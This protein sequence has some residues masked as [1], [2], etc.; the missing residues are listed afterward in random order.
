MT[1]KQRA[2]KQL[3]SLEKMYLL[4]ENAFNKWKEEND[5][6]K[7]LS[8]L[9]RNMKIIMNRK[10]LPVARKWILYQNFLA[11][12]ANFKR[13]IREQKKNE[14]N[15]IPSDTKTSIEKKITL[16]RNRANQTEEVAKVNVKTN[17]DGNIVGND[18]VF[19]LNESD[20]LDDD[21]HMKTAEDLMNTIKNNPSMLQ[22]VDLTELYDEENSDDK[23][24]ETSNVQV[25][26]LPQL[27]AKE[28]TEL[29][30][31]HRKYDNFLISE[32][33]IIAHL[34]KASKTVQD[35]YRNLNPIA[36]T[37]KIQVDGEEHEIDL[38]KTKIDEDDILIA[39]DTSG[40]QI[41]IKASDLSNDDL[42]SI[43]SYLTEKHNQIESYIDEEMRESNKTPY[44]T[45]VLKDG[46][47]IVKF[48]NDIV[49][50]DGEV[51]NY[52]ED[53][54]NSGY[55]ASNVTLRQIL[56]WGKQHV[57]G[58]KYLSKLPRSKNRKTPTS[59]IAS[60]GPSSSSTPIIHKEKKT[61]SS[62]L[63]KRSQECNKY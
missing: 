45:V 59:A 3:T 28:Q 11:R 37:K 47:T 21:I 51:L 63:N 19:V 40:G 12:Y 42:Y 39:E 32:N 22:N 44:E 25:E 55:E 48:K 13:F 61:I 53:Y 34:N 26:R 15:N 50:A 58:E 62:K 36:R 46:T 5:D 18:E 9:D 56:S 10:D 54:L 7:Q 4:D 16:K 6:K 41:T 49:K 2:G 1:S 24:L 27:T 29:D 57:S 31:L 43:H 23:T 60:Y 17:T 52:I 30:E 14:S 20:E 8:I 33:T 38:N 35:A